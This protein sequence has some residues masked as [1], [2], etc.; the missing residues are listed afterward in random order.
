M[1]WLC[2]IWS[3]VAVAELGHLRVKDLLSYEPSIQQSIV[4]AH[5]IFSK[6]WLWCFHKNTNNNR[7]LGPVRFY[8]LGV[9]CSTRHVHPKNQDFLGIE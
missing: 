8:M 4:A 5:W 2:L 1:L 6:G 9:G 3:D 7:Q